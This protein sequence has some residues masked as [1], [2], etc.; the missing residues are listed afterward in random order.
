MTYVLGRTGA[1]LD[2]VTD[3]SEELFG[4]LQPDGTVDIINIGRGG[5][6]LIDIGNTGTG[7]T[8]AVTFT[9]GNGLVGSI[10]TA[11]SATSFVTSSDPRLKSFSGKPSDTDINDKFALLF[12]SFDTF[13]WKSDLDGSLVWGFNAH[14]CI[15]NGLDMGTEGEGPRTSQLGGGITPA[16]VDQS[17]AVPILLAKIEQLE[18]RI[19]TLEA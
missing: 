3:Q 4:E 10:Q 13:N 7:G 5:K 17:K 8:F 14:T 12:D 9:N 15:D 1:S 18:R 11:A 19:A 6:G 2:S 16:G